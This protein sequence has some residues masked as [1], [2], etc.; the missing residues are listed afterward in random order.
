ML[1]TLFTT[2][3]FLLLVPVTLSQGV[4]HV[5]G[6]SIL[7]E[8][9]GPRLRTIY[10]LEGKR[11]FHLTR[12]GFFDLEGISATELQ[13]TYVDGHCSRIVATTWMEEGKYSVEY[14][15]EGKTLLFTYETIEYFE[16]LSRPSLWR[17]FKG[18]ASWERRTYFREEEAGYVESKGV[19]ASSSPDPKQLVA[20]GNRLH[21]ELMSR[22]K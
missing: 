11:V 22:V 4:E 3:C 13:G 15:W 7:K 17:N 21:D 14:Y 18:L 20:S 6:D 12:E 8:N 9:I 5:V 16:E 1:K 2:I 10:G 19:A